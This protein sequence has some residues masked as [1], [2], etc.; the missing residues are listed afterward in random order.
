MDKTNLENI[1]LGG[2]PGDNLENPPSSEV[3]PT[4]SGGGQPLFSNGN[5]EKVTLIEGGMTTAPKPKPGH[6]LS[7][8]LTDR[9]RSSS[10]SDALPSTRFKNDLVNHLTTHREKLAHN[11]SEPPPRGSLGEWVNVSSNK[12]RRSSPETTTRIQKQTKLSN[13]WLSSP[14]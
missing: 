6:L 9:R 1:T 8:L 11:E 3:G 10:F 2:S 5:T 4:D 14:V 13:Y 12:R 7:N